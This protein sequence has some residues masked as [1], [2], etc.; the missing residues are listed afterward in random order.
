[1]AEFWWGAAPPGG[2]RHHDHFYPACRGK[3]RPILP[4]MLDGLNVQPPRYEAAADF[5]LSEPEVL[6]EDEHIV[7]LLKPAGM[8]SVAGK[9]IADSVESRLQSRYSVPVLNNPVSDKP[10]PDKKPRMFG[11]DRWF[12]T[13]TASRQQ[14]AI[15]FYPEQISR[16]VCSFSLLPV[17]P[18]NLEYT[19]HI[20]MV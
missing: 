6:F 13:S 5:P 16:P 3:C 9:T 7:I 11:P 19:W 17:E 14:P 15:T 18:T 12:V 20:L 4:H 10:M 2:V 1:M 8:L